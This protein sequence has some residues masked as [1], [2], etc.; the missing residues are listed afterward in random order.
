MTQGPYVLTTAAYNEERHIASTLRSVV[1]QNIRPSKWVIVSDG[2]TDGTDRIVQG[3]AR[4]YPFIEFVRLEKSDSHSFSAKVRALRVGFQLLS[5]TDYEFIGV[6]DADLSFEPDYFQSVLDRF[7]N[8]PK[9]GIAGGNIAQ[10]VDGKLVPRL[11]DMNSVAGAVQLLRRTCFEQTGGLP[12]LEH[13][14]EDAAM[15]ISARKSSGSSIR[16]SRL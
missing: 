5:H 11:K 7:A 2:S 3:W 14:G 1:R 6:L 8:E 9:L 10:L 13:G 4:R 15:E 16:P 12:A